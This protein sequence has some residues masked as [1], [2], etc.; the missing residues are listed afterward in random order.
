MK[1]VLFLATTLCLMVSCID[2]RDQAALQVALKVSGSNRSELEKVLSH[3]SSKEDSLQ[4]RAAR[5]LIVNMSDHYADYGDEINKY[6]QV[7]SIID[8][9]SYRQDVVSVADRMRIGDSLLHLY[10]NPNLQRLEKIPDM[11]IITA[12][13]LIANI[14]FAFKAWKTAPWSRKVGFD[15][16]CEY[17]LP[18]R[19]RDEQM[20]YWRPQYYYEYSRMAGN[21]RQ[22]DSPRR[23]FYSMRWDLGFENN[24]TVYFSKYFPFR[25][26]IS[27]ILK[28]KV[29]GCETTS[30]FVTTAMRSAG[31]PVALDYIPHWGNA[32]NRHYMVSLVD[33]STPVSL[34]SNQNKPVNTWYLVD[35]SSETDAQRHIFSVDELPPGLDIQYVRTIPKVYR[36][37]FSRDSMLTRINR[38]IPAGEIS[39]E[40]RSVN[41]KDVTQ[42]YITCSDYNLSPGPA[43]KKYKLAYLCAFDITGWKPIAIA[44]MDHGRALFKNIGRN[45]MYL[46]AVYR[47]GEMI[48]A[49]NPFF[50]DSL[51]S[52]HALEKEQ[53]EFQSEHLIRKTALYSYTA[54]HTEVVKGG[55]FE[56]G[57]DPGFK[58][59]V[60][61]DSIRQYPFYMNEITIKAPKHY[62]YLRYVAPN[63][64]VP[65]PDNIA[66]IQFFEAG[67]PLALKGQF[68]GSEGSPGHEI[69]KA[70]DNNLDSYY[71]NKGGKNGWIGLDLGKK[72]RAKIARIRFCPRNDTN[73]ILPGEEYELFY[74]DTQWVSLGAKKATNYYLDYSVVPAGTLY[75]L[76]CNSGGEEER[77]FSYEHG[78][79]RWW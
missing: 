4:R 12:D 75:W 78:V 33:H 16:F 68:T 28:G 34:I 47:D 59:P 27:D 38:S 19:V 32:N 66:E 48:P 61:L 76:R 5:F 79:Q 20:Q 64:K 55:R 18:Y 71:E 6:R 43:F 35:F 8:T 24:F 22:N 2:N 74:W 3:Y 29:G 7:F 50:I 56:G 14:D 40:F 11:K 77:I 26:S 73:C 9:L 60:L 10:G 31:L 49:G 42:E 13:Y 1:T 46:P 17:I 51:N 63:T 21:Y 62:R 53:G 39:P 44:T 58:H 23:I 25:Q 65:E 57:D 36:Y 45:T 41:F 70:F 69:A 52:I 30:L 72:S 54:Y 67:S 15:D 37:T